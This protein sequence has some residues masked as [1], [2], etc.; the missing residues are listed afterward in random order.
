MG[1]IGTTWRELVAASTRAEAALGFGLSN[2][3][4]PT[5]PVEPYA[6]IVN[7][8]RQPGMFLGF[9]NVTT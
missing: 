2:L 6:H 1:A 9:G 4:D 8:Q 3:P 5:Y 7:G